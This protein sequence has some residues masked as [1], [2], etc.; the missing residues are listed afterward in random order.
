[1][2]GN[3]ENTI[4][5]STFRYNNAYNGG[6]IFG[7]TNKFT[8]SNSSFSYNEASNSGG[9]ISQT[10]G[11]AI[12][13]R[14]IFTWNTAVYAGALGLS[15]DVKITNSVIS[16]NN[17]MYSG[18]LYYEGEVVWD[19]IIHYLIMHNCDVENNTAMV[20]GGAF[21]FDDANVNI[22]NCNI[23]NN[24]APTYSTVF[25]Q[26]YN[27]NIYAV[28]NWWGSIYGP[29]DSVWNAV[30]YFRTWLSERVNWGSQDNGNSTEGPGTNGEVIILAV[31]TV[32]VTVTVTGMGM[33]T[34][35]AFIG[36]LV[37]VLD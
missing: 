11:L 32:T 31:P 28:G 9:A 30:Q 6:A 33:V 10:V 19:H 34:V 23:V 36:V 13:D 18:G 29:D 20:R 25:A 1:M 3:A 17:A 8:I 35:T 5:N 7:G 14:S 12:I 2:V 24:F 4:L 26:N 21:G 15:G 22:T 16:N 37:L 27:T